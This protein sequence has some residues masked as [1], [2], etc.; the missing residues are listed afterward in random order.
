MTGQKVN[1]N[2]QCVTVMDT[3]L[4]DGEQTSGVAFS[5]TEKVSVARILLEDVGVDRIEVASARVSEGEFQ[6]AKK[7]LSWAKDR[8]YDQRVEILGFVDGD[9]SLNWIKNAGGKVI[10]LLCKGSYKHVTQQL[11]KTPEQ[12]L[13]DIRGVIAK[14]EEMGIEVN[15]YLEDWSNGMRHSRD[16]VHF[17]VSSLQ[18]EQVKR[19][20]LPDT[21]GIL[22]PDE[23]Y[24]FCK[25][26]IETYPD[27]VFDFHAHND[28]DLAIANVFHAIKAGIRCVHTTV[29]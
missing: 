11:R 4:R 20:M 16:Y 7:I 25:E 5:D 2:N 12:H 18:K 22:D 23:T 6:G 19:I 17:M 3:T 10:N 13:D 24:D 9:I 8:G 21:L 1:V 29:N 28:Y 27:V 15:I 26:M 14:A